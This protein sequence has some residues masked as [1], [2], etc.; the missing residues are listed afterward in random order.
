MGKASSTKKVARA[1]R[2]GGRSSLGQS[3]NLLFPTVL[4]LIIVLGT[5]L[6]VFARQDRQANADDTPPQLGDHIHMA[7]GTYVCDAYLPDQPEWENP[8]GI[9]S[10]GDGVVHGH[11][12]SALG[13]GRNANLALYLRDSGIKLT[14]A[15]L[16]VNGETYEDGGKC[17]KEEATLQVLRWD[18][19]SDEA[20]RITGDLG[21]VTLDT[22][23]GSIAVVFAP[24]SANIP[25]PPTAA[26]LAELG[27]ADGGD[28]VPDESATSSTEGSSESTSSTAAADSTTSTT[29][30]P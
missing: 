15:K 8:E 12:S 5:A 30:T 10:H 13:T 24:V 22:N 2:A 9:H 7:Y 27:A 3:R 4:G 1:A 21:K 11:P 29:T 28:T 16:E 23:G 14:D 26:N 18:S 20:T 17:G 25:K 6:I 19:E